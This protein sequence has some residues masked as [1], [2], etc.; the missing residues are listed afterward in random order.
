VS[1][2]TPPLGGH[3]TPEAYEGG[4]WSGSWHASRQKLNHIRM[5]GILKPCRYGTA[6]LKEGLKE[7]FGTTYINKMHLLFGSSFHKNSTVKR[8]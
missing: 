7:L 4:E 2:V 8:A 1:L 6:W 3:V 5:R